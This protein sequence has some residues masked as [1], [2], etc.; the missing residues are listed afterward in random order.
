MNSVGWTSVVFAVLG[1]SVAKAFAVLFGLQHESFLLAVLVGLL[2][3]VLCF[4]VC[5]LWSRLLRGTEWQCY[6]P[7]G[8]AFGLSVFMGSPASGAF[9]FAVVQS[10][11]L[12]GVL[13]VISTV[14]WTS[15]ASAAASD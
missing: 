9:V 13:L 3:G 4:C 2:C 8:P 11:W 1:S 10:T 12:R 15:F 14:V 7:C 5:E 6:Q